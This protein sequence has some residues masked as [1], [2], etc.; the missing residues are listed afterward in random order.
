MPFI[1]HDLRRGGAAA[2]F[3]LCLLCAGAYAA[4]S[5]RSVVLDVSPTLVSLHVKDAEQRAVLVELGRQAGCCFAANPPELFAAD[6]P[7]VSLDIA[8]APF[9]TVMKQVCDKTSLYP[10]YLERQSYTLSGGLRGWMDGPS[11]VSGAFLVVASQAVRVDS[12]RFA[13]PDVKIRDATIGLVVLPE[14]K[15]R[16]LRGT[17]HPRLE[18]VL[19]EKG[20]SLIGDAAV[21]DGGLVGGGPFAWN[22]EIKLPAAAS[23]TRISLLKGQCRYLVA[24]SCL[25]WEIPDILKVAN[26]TK[27]AGGRTCRIISVHKDV[28]RGVEQVSVTLGITSTGRDVLGQIVHPAGIEL[29]DAEG[30]PYRFR[31]W[32]RIIDRTPPEYAFHF[33]RLAEGDGPMPGEP[34]KLTWDI[35]TGAEEVAVPFEFKDL[36]LP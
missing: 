20:R 36:P 2:V 3:V 6:R 14:P 11:V 27:T 4:E 5:D 25:R 18:K 33:S 8:K 21:A 22:V 17:K 31:G 7:R 32:T 23:A 10:S 15:L 24:N 9:W 34:A 29:C 1:P 16:V 19:D 13:E 26:A 12:L 28:N 30:R 35:I